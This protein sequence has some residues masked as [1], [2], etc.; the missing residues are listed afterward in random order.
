M[1]RLKFPWQAIP[2]RATTELEE[3]ELTLDAIAGDVD[4]NWTALP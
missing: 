3:L 4:E 2:S 1:T